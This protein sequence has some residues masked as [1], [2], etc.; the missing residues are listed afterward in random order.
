MFSLDHLA[1][2]VRSL[3]DAAPFWA[4]L[5]G[6]NEDGREEV[7]GEGVRVAF[8]GEGE[9]RIELLEP[10]DPDGAVG[11]YLER[12]G[13]GLHHVC[14]AVPDLDAALERAGEAGAEPVPPR[15]RRGAGGRRVAFLHPSSTG[16]VLLELAERT[17]EGGPDGDGSGAG[18]GPAS[19]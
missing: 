2:A 10:T 8:F 12:S 3:E 1:I 7:P 17:G 9:G 14:L 13:P 5:L 15:I 11:R 19:G 6:R 16:G 4:A 18:A